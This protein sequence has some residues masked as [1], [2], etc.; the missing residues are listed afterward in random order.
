LRFKENAIKLSK[1]FHDQPMKP[2][3]LAVYWVEYVISHNGAHHLKT[4]GNQLNWFQFM[5][6]DVIF[7][8]IIFILIFIFILYYILEKMYKT[9]MESDESDTDTDNNKKKE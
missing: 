2:L 7:E 4:A 5:L 8:F 3:D 6:I 9:F 1:L